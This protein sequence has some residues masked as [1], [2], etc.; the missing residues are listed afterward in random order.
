MLFR[1]VTDKCLDC[2]TK[3]ENGWFPKD[4]FKYCPI[5]WFRK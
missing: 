4:K 2:G 1:F 3:Y 5:C